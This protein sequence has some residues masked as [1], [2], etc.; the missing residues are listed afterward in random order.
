M[1]RFTA[2]TEEPHKRFHKKTAILITNLG[3]P[4]APTPAALRTYLAEFLSDSRIVEIPRL[5]WKVILHGIILR[6][7]PR[8]SAKLYKSIWTEGGS[9]LLVYSKK[10][11]K[12]LASLLKE[13]GNDGSE[14]FLAMRYGN[15]SI[16]SVLEDIREKGYRRIV[17]LP[18]YPQY[19]G[20][21]TGSTYDAI[22]RE[23]VNWRWVPELHFIN[24]YQD[25]PH[26]IDSLAASI[27]E[28]LDAN[29]MPEKLVLSYHGTPK[30]F[31]DKGDPY[32]CFCQMTTR[33]VVEKLGLDKESVITT[34]QSRF[35]KAEWLK[36]YTDETLEQLAKDG[37]KNIAIAS[38]AFS[39]DCLETLEELEEENRE[40][41]MEAGGENYRYIPALNDRDDHIEA[42]YQILNPYL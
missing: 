24:G 23:L 36:P 26:Y 1:S 13:K 35:G 15:P 3:S 32:H 14:V 25:N 16:K 27:K 22:S 8:R 37:I 11:Q 20:S 9:P 39:S 17:V 30:F 18:L 4:D 29:G 31:L 42:F 38:P 34:F 7:R 2:V 5:I 12:K 6:T 33:L 10:Q 28:D 21:T 40:I 41:F 19:S